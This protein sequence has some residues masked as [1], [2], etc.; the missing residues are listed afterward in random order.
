MGVLSMAGVSVEKVLTSRD[1][2]GAGST[3]PLA[4]SHW[5]LANTPFRFRPAASSHQPMAI[6]PPRSPRTSPRRGT[7]CGSARRPRRRIGPPVRGEA[8]ERRRVGG[9]VDVHVRKQGV[10][11][12]RSSRSFS[13]ACVLTF[14]AAA[15]LCLRI[16]SWASC[17][18][19][20]ARTAAMSRFS[21]AMNGSSAAR[22]ASITFGYTT[23]PEVT[24][25]A[26]SSTPSRARKARA[27]SAGGRTSRRAC[28]RTTARPR[29]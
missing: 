18:S 10:L 9:G 14:S 2:Q 8:D 5:P 25:V 12:S 20:P 21:V 4:M 23:S 24:S 6:T 7:A 28:V 3:W 17:R 22:F 11:R 1:R 15:R 13:P 27:A 19:A 16:A 29:W 26:R